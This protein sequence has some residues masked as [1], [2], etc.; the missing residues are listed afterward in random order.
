MTFRVTSGG[1][2]PR[3]PRPLCPVRDQVGAGTKRRF[4]P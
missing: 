3:R 4:G 1:L 2:N